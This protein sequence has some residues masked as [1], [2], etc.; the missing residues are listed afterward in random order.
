MGRHLVRQPPVQPRDEPLPRPHAPRSVATRP[1]RP[2]PETPR[3][4]APG[5]PTGVP[6]GLTVADA[7]RIAAAIAACHADSTRTIYAGAWNRW[8]RWCAARQIEPMP[9]GPAAICAYLTERA[10]SGL[11]IGAL[12]TD[13]SAIAYQ[14]RR[15]RLPDPL[16]DEAVRAVRRGLRRIVGT[17]PRRQARPL[18]TTEIRQIVATLDRD[19]PKGARDA[20]IILLGFASALRRSELAA[21]TLADIDTRPGGL[22]VTVRRSKTDQEAAGQRVGVAHGQHADTDPVAALRAWEEVRGTTAGPLFT[23]MRARRVTL[24]PLYGDGIALMLRTRA[25][26]AGL[27]AERITPHSIRAGHATEAAMNGVAIDRIAVQTRHRR[28]STLLERYIRP[29]QALQLT[30]SRDLGL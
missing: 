21:L 5:V 20:A 19:T 12:D 4:D 9:A 8:Q 7:T 15:H 18:G 16:C 1:G 22:V 13:C 17:A 2:T 11:S 30:T 26:A 23:S 6:A 28:L 24:E 10:A 25:R 3:G 14:H 27:T 29:A